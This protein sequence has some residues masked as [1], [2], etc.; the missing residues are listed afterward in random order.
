[1][2]ISEILSTAKD[3]VTRETRG[4]T[5]MS[6]IKTARRLVLQGKDHEHRGNHKN[7]LAAYTQAAALAKMTLDSAEMKAEAGR[8]G[9]LKKEFNDFFEHE[10]NDLAERKN[11][12]EDK[13]KAFEKSAAPEDPPPRKTIADRLKSLQDNGLVVATNSKRLSREL[14]TSPPASSSS[15]PSTSSLSRPPIS[16]SSSSSPPVP[17]APSQPPALSVSPLLP[18]THA[19]VSPPALGPPSP[20]STSSSVPSPGLAERESL[21]LSEFAT[22]FPP[23]DELD[24][25]VGLS[26]PSV[27]TSPP[28]SSSRSNHPEATVNGFTEYGAPVERPSST[29]LTPTTNV[30]NS[31]PTSPSR[32]SASPALRSKPS[33]AGLSGLGQG[34]ASVATSSG[35]TTPQ[36]PTDR[37]PLPVTNSV[38][39]KEL[40][41]YIKQ[42]Y[43]I[44]LL[45]VR[46]RA[47]FD[48]EHIKHKPVVCVEPS[49]L[50]RERVT[51][52]TLE[53][54]LVVAP[55]HEGVV[56]SNREK[57]DLVVLYDQN[58]TNFGSQDSPINVLVGAIYEGAIHKMLRRVPRLLIGGLDQWKA[59]MGDS[60]VKRS[61]DGKHSPSYQE[62]AT[63]KG[64]NGHSHTQSVSGAI[65]NGAMSPGLNG[66]MS[67]PLVSTNGSA[68]TSPR[69]DSHQQWTSPR[70]RSDTNPFVSP[71]FDQRT[72]AGLP[73]GHGD[74]RSTMSVDHVSHSR[75]PAEAS[76]PL[77]QQPPNSLVRRP[78]ISRAP[79]STSAAYPAN[80]SG[81]A[82]M[83]SISN[84]PISP[85]T[86][87][88]FPPRV[89][90][91]ATGS[92]G[93]PFVS[94]PL[95]YDNIASPPQAS[96]NPS[97]PRRRSD[98]VD[99]SQ[100]ALSG[101][102][103]ANRGSIDYPELSTQ[104]SRP[105][106]VAAPAI[107]LDR[108]ENHNRP[109][110]TPPTAPVPP[111]L[112]QDYNVVYW[113]DT[114]IGTSGLK[115][116]GNTCYM[117]APIQCLS[118]TVPFAQFFTNG[119]WKEAI[120]MLNR[121]GSQGRLVQAFATLLRSMWQ[122]DLP[123]ITPIDFRKIVVS[124]ND[125][126][127]GSDQHDSQEFLSFLLDIIH[128]DLNRVIAKPVWN[129]TPE[130]EAELEKLPP[131][132]AS[133]REWKAWK[134]RN[135]SLI[136]DY[137][138]GQL[139]NRLQCMTCN[140]TSTT[141]NV[142]SMLQLPVPSKSSKIPLQ[143]CLDAFFNHEVLEKDDAWVCPRCKTKRKATKQLSLAR[144]PPILLINLKRFETHGRFSDKVDTF[145]EFPLK[146]LDLTNL[147][148]PP[149]P[150]GADKG[151]VS[152]DP[153][154]PRTQLPPYRYD[155]YGV[156]NHYGN[157]SSGHYTAYI[158]SRGGWVTCDD[159]SVRPVDAKQ[160]VN[161]KAYVLFYKR[162][163]A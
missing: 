136:V 29:P 79:V 44:L 144:L 41:Q 77:Y 132:I 13:L 123:Y 126:Y 8:A 78:A 127:H 27:P 111:R 10:G 48:R 18:S 31:R 37:P 65:V 57:F 96:I 34:L 19:T 104:I 154:D 85:I 146:G 125:Q 3:A 69:L 114:Q 106:P 160:V 4:A 143:K 138:Q 32:S 115:N 38:T 89:T 60:W 141:Y 40:H 46:N 70:L 94:P 98:Y 5:P 133:E 148:P 22:A 62:P 36:T 134:M 17:S 15:F 75:I 1:M 86:Y 103:L 153:N 45:D 105:P 110:A 80:L 30:F 108:Q 155:L 142:F 56:F 99:Q 131:Q 20:A 28:A 63:H 140:Q 7:A 102:G 64:V 90:P 151:Q 88:Q 26:L 137:F 67:P 11:A 112:K 149:L 84:G 39:P 6:M 97:F 16:A 52:Q 35:S 72:P 68:A 124:L 158:A 145:V 150:A 121:M 14:P 50:L 147:M 24:N 162:V 93:S 23:I 130:E 76:P 83:N 9:V 66:S 92:F 101:S 73:M 129:P 61:N 139:R 100:E 152:I 87:P 95:H 163:K 128:E 119:R 157:L 117:N 12:V 71:T 59:E 81:P 55:A 135:D 54:A 118:A 156:T 53:D 42:A 107:A 122:G 49:I 120:N 21:S 159:S 116:M 2:T 58:S 113:Y 43:K 74:H 91:S 47:D 33:T 109:I 51:G 25:V 161:Q 82:M